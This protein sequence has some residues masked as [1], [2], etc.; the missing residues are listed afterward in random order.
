MGGEGAE[1]FIKNRQV[2]EKYSSASDSTHDD[3]V[4]HASQG[5]EKNYPPPPPPPG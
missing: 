4:T 5:I 3:K 1:F 2:E